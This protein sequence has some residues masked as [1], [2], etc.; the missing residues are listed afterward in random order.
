MADLK[1][2]DELELRNALALIMIPGLVYEVRVLEGRERAEGWASQ[3]A[4]WFTEIDAIAR[5]LGRLRGGWGAAYLAP[6]PCDP[7]LL[8]K[9]ANKLVK[10]KRGEQTHDG[11]ITRRLWL[12]ADFDPVVW[13]DAGEV[14]GIAA[15]DDERAAAHRRRDEVAAHLQAAGLPEP[16]VAD[17]GNGGHL[18]FRTD[19]PP[20]S[21][22]PERFIKACAALWGDDPGSER[23]GWNRSA[24]VKIDTSIAN[25][26][27]IW[28]LYGTLACKGAGVGD[29]PWRMA[30][31]V[32][33]PPGGLDVLSEAELEAW[34]VA[35]EA[36]IAAA[37]PAPAAAP[38]S[39]PPAPA[40]GP[41]GPAGAFDALELVRSTG[42]QVGEGKRRADGATFYEL[43]EC[44][45][46]RKTHRKATISIAESGA[47]GL[48]CVHES[49]RWSRTK[50]SPGEHW[51]TWRAEHD[52]SYRPDGQAAGGV[53]SI[54]RQAYAEKLGQAAPQAIAPPGL[55]VAGL[56]GVAPGEAVPP[57][58]P[59]ELP[60]PPPTA[61]ETARDGRQRINV[62]Q[63][64]RALREQVI[65]ALAADPRLYVSHGKI[66]RVAGSRMFELSAGALDSAAVD[67]C[68]FVKFKR[69]PVTGAFV[70]IP[71][72][73]PLRVRGMLEALDDGAAVRFRVVEQVTRTPFWTAAGRPW[74]DA[75]YCAEARTVLVDPPELI[76][77]PEYDGAG[78]LQYLR[79]LVGDF[80]FQGGPAGA[81]VSNLIGAML[82]PMV[83][84]LISGPMPMLLIE[85]NLPGLGKSLLA[86]A[87]RVIYGLESEAGSLPRDEERV[88]A[89]MLGI[90]KKS[91]PVHVFDD[92]THSVISATLNRAIT[93]RTYSDRVLG[94][95]DTASYV[96]RQLWIMTLNNAR[97]SADIVRRVFRC[98]LLWDRPGRPEERRDIRI[99]D[100]VG[101]VEAH[102]VEILS[103]LWQLVSEWIEAGRPMP[104]DLP[105]FGSF[106]SFASV[107]GGILRHAGDRA[108]LTNGAE[109]KED[110]A[111]DDEWGPFVLSW[112]HDPAIGVHW[113]RGYKPS[114]LWS[115]ATEKGLLGSII[116][117]GGNEAAQVAR[118]SSILKGKRDCVYAGWRIVGEKDDRGQWLYRLQEIPTQGLFA[119]Q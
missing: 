17:S 95:S 62:A 76:E 88:Q 48:Q 72:S 63:D 40:R 46:D 29:R 23:A 27:R 14:K 117:Q 56:L 26:A 50:A 1:L 35:A 99:R 11:Q 36:R 31:V 39:A 34:I 109:V 13:G 42:L 60:K 55:D 25:A 97:A 10:A 68:E 91:E 115:F 103:R 79:D 118:V 93:G 4:G 41:G 75:G 114:A 15:T 21:P 18:M 43:E 84:P 52:P 70:P 110:L 69:D 87:I 105:V 19:L 61:P 8:H 49:C 106:E 54:E 7:L 101:H 12:L 9:S 59:L 5:E 85:G 90:L 98:R 108:W 111:L 83:R 16:L 94:V 100:F 81:E 92:V 6:N 32:S 73:L 53:T 119:L 51:R 2:I 80:P 96:I 116:G 57:P 66:A 44:A 78:C 89:L 65:T 24:T 47:V 38:P 20:D 67:A 112:A 64:L 30:R 102:R 82:A 28:K 74:R 104:D 58:P 45:C 22:L 3:W 113:G 107:I 37:R 33:T 77:R 86:S 71:E